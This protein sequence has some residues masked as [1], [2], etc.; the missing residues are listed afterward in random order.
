MRSF[1]VL[2]ICAMA[3]AS[4]A[5]VA[6]TRKTLDFPRFKLVNGKLDVDKDGIEMPASGASLCLVGGAKTCFQM[7]PHQET[8]GKFMYQFARDPLSERIALKGGGS[9]AFFSASYYSVE[10]LKFD[11]LA[12]LRYEENGRLTD[13]LPYIAVSFQGEHAMWTLPDISA[14]PV[15]VTADLYWDFNANETRWD[16][17]RYFVEA[18]R[19]DI[20]SDRY[21][22]LF[23][24]LTKRKYAS[25]DHKPVRVLGPERD[26]V[27]RRLRAAAQP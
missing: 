4:V 24:Y 19:D 20:S 13:L 21:V 6:Q 10:P 23:K 7:A 15:L 2:I 9:L 1:R 14:M 17:H 18:Y 25:G 11:R 12:L 27:L 26:E 16:D 3:A 8:D 22:F 5:A